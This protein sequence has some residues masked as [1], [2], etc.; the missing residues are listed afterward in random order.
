MVYGFGTAA[1]YIA[2]FR[3]NNSY[4]IWLI[5]SILRI[6]KGLIQTVVWYS[7][8]LI[9]PHN[10]IEALIMWNWTKGQINSII[11]ASSQYQRI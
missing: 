5:V 10:R 11:P 2:T 4:Y 9:Q 6:F 3:W 1:P 8:S 7:I